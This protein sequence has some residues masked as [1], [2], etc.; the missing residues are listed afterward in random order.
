MQIDV[1]FKQSDSEFDLGMEGDSTPF[2]FSV[3]NGYRIIIDHDTPE[4]TGEY[5]AIPSQERQVFRTNGKRMGEDFVVE[6]IPSN[7]GLITWDGS[8]LTVS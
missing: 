1:N 8:V 3:E 4:Y 6:P 5:S 7:Y 2:S